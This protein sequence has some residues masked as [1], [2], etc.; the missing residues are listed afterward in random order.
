[1]RCAVL[2]LC[3]KLTRRATVKVLEG[4]CVPC[5]SSMTLAGIIKHEVLVLKPHQYLIQ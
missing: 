2:E 4:V 1:M 3:Q 5:A